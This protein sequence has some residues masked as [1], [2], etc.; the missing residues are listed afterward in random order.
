MRIGDVVLKNYHY[1]LN[2][3]STF[4][5]YGAT[6][7][8]LLGLAPDP[9]NTRVLQAP[10]GTYRKPNR[11]F[12]SA[13]FHQKQIPKNAVAFYNEPTIEFGVSP[14]GSLTLG[15]YDSSLFCGKLAKVPR[16]TGPTSV[17]C[18]CA[19]ASAGLTR[20]VW[21][22]DSSFEYNGKTLPIRDNNGTRH[23]TSAMNVD[24]GSSLV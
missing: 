2:V 7:D 12:V 20:A 3:T 13:A 4:G 23:K 9:G 15:G 17:R 16:S 21:D 11:N 8:G 1:L 19:L 6:S 10:D 14:L 24:S 18:A 5:G 22:V